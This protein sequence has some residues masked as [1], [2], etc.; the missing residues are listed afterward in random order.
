MIPVEYQ[1]QQANLKVV[2]VDVT[3]KLA[4]LGRNWLEKIRLDWA[5]LFRVEQPWLDYLSGRFPNL[6]SSALGTLKG[7]EARITVRPDSKP[8]FHRPRPV[9]YALQKKVD[10]ELDRLQ[11]EGVLVG[12]EKSDWAA[13]IVVVRKGDGSVR[14]CGDYKVTINPFLDMSQYPMPNPRDLFATLVGGKRFT[15]LNLK[16]AYQQMRVSPDSQQYL[17]VNTHKG[18]FAYTRMPFGISSAPGIWQKAMD[19]ILAGIPGVLCYLDDML[20]VGQNEGEHNERLIAV[21]ERL[22]RAGMK[23][24]IDKCEFN[25]PRVEYLGMS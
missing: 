1:E 21:L 4:I 17:T 9:P 25:Q 15:R 12:V 14:V 19:S 2:V 22:D 16:Q 18:L 20:V 23:L 6:F 10:E 13:P 7:H 11:S 24:K 3:N 8:G 5:S